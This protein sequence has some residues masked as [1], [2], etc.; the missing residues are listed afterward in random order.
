MTIEIAFVLALTLAAL[1]LFALDR[2][3]LDQVAMAVPVVLLLTGILTPAQAVSGLSSRATVTVGSMLVLGLGLRKTGL[4][5][6]IGT[7]AR[8]APLGG[9]YTRL[10]VLCLVCATLSPFLM[11]TAVVM[12]FIPVFVALAEQAEEPVSRYLMPLSFVSILGGTVT[13]MGTSTNLVVHGEAMRRGFDE[14]RMFSI[15]PMGL[16]CLAVGLLY[17]FTAGRALLPRRTRPPDLS[18]KY[19]VRSF[20]TELHVPDDSPANGQTL[21]E[22]GWGE[23]YDVQV[24]DIERSD[25]EVTAPHGDRH[26]RPGDI[27]YVQGS[28][29]RLVDLARRQRLTIP[30][31]GARQGRD[32]TSEGG[33]LVELLLAPGST[34]VGRTLRESS[35]GQRYEAT[36]L[37]VQQ[38]GVTV[39]E[40]LADLRL[41]VGDLILVHGKA[42]ALARLA[43]EPGFVP[44]GE[45]RAAGR[46]PRAGVAAAIMASVV[47]SASTGVLDIMTAALAGVGLMVFTGCV[48]VE[49]IYAEV[50]WLV[51]FVL[52]GLI[53]LGVALE[54]TGAAQM[55]A[56][57]VV[58][59]T[60]PLGEVGLIAAFYLVTASMTA[61]VSNAA[62]AVM[63][64][65]V[66]ILAATQAGVNP[67]ALLV[68]VMF[69]ASAS[70]V[71][72]FGY[73]TNVMIFGPGGYRFS[74]FVKVGGLLNLILLVT[75]SIFIPIFW[76]S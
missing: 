26:I 73:Q 57:W 36:V 17:L 76:R 46:R 65:P 12:V 58:G 15:T 33:R 8:T 32:V 14:L 38:H 52:A 49:E 18:S 63:L 64:T 21:A 67:Y 37:A 53:P 35:F 1:V 7:W 56:G 42:P 47:L 29:E 74:D 51:I 48:R 23:R 70:F 19:D 11:T 59:L 27:L 30:G 16:I 5:S 69:G 41:R 55:L 2:M 13:L 44:I 6:A 40:R 3:R 61:I 45:V 50:E 20:V 54:A 24:L 60:A 71:T 34:L 25:R 31:E 43:D 10:F 28:A 72:P 68:A 39:T 9:K 62:T 75:A 4:V 22:L 66:A